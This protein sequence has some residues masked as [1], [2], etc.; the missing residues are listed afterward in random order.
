MLEGKE[1]ISSEEK[2]EQFG[3]DL[4]H[5]VL[6]NEKVSSMISLLEETKVMPRKGGIRE[7][8]KIIPEVAEFANSKLLLSLAS[9]YLAG[10]PFLVRA[11]YFNKSQKNNW[12]VTWHQDKTVTVSNKMELDGWGP[13]TLKA[14]VHHVQPPLEVLEKMVTIRVHLDKTTKDNGCLKVAPGS[15]K[16]DLLATSDVLNKIQ[17]ID[18]FFCE[19]EAGDAVVMRPHIVHS[20]EKA[21]TIENRRILHFEYSC[22][23]LPEGMSWVA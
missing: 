22:F 3:F 6:S 8:D 4:V 1:M 21:K 17:N 14:N 12:L 5:S 15:H 10:N 16:Q 11:I 18:P 19:V 2:V 13:W 9:R 20:S 23:E 7:I